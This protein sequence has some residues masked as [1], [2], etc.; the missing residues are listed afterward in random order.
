MLQCF[1]LFKEYTKNTYDALPQQGLP[2]Q[3]LPLF[4]LAQLEVR[5]NSLVYFF[6]FP[7]VWLPL[8]ILMNECKDMR[9]LGWD[10]GKWKAAAGSI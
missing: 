6:L 7:V 2:Q 3:P 1:I 9:Q 5:Q 10:T 4:L 8:K